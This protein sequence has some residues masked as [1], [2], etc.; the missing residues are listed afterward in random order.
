MEGSAVY[1][2][3]KW[4]GKNYDLLAKNLIEKNKFI[5]FEKLM[6]NSVFKKNDQ[7]N[8][9]IQSGSFCNYLITNY[10]MEKFI[11]L[12]KNP[13]ALKIYDK[14]LTELES[15]WKKY[16]ENLITTIK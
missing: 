14:S 13:D 5:S 4:Y 3:G 15:D 11:E 16:L 10:G 12:W 9:Y 6:K 8:L 1:S 7:A 2:D